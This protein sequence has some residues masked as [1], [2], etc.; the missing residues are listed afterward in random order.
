MPSK[1]NF[2][3]ISVLCSKFSDSWIVFGAKNDRIYSAAKIAAQIIS[4]AGYKRAPAQN[5]AGARLSERAF[6]AGFFVARSQAPPVCAPRM[7]FD[8]L[9]CKK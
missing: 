3:G 9:I 7:G 4:R 2:G 8:S 5:G 1:Q 6:C